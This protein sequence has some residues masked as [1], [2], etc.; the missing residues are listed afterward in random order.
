[1]SA[2][3]T[4]KRVALL[5][6]LA[7]G[8][9]RGAAAGLL[10]L[11]TLAGPRVAWGAPAA[12]TLS[13]HAGF[14][15]YYK[16]LRWLPVRITVAN[17]G[18]DTQ[19]T[20]RVTVPR[21]GGADV[22]VTRDVDLPTQS[23]REVF[24][25]I[26]TEG[27]ISNL[28]VSLSDGQKE[29]AT[30]VTRL[31]QAGTGDLIYG[32]LAG[33]P[34]AFNILSGVKPVSGSAYVAQLEAADL[35]PV[36]TAWHALD[37]LVISDVDTGVL[38]P[39]QRTALSEWVAS[40]GRLIVTGGPTWQKT[41]AGLGALLP[42]APAGTQTLPDASA[43]AAFASATTPPGS[44]VAATG[45]LGPDAVTLVS[46]GN[47]PIVVT[48]HSGFG[49]VLFLAIDPSFDPLKGWSGLEGLYRNLLS[50]T[51]QRPNWATGLRNWYAARDAVNALPGLQLPSALQVCGFLGVY[52]LAVGPINYLVLRRFKRRELAWLTVPL[53][54]VVFSGGAYLT[55]YQLRGG[56]ASL[57]RLAVVQVWPNADHAR[58]DGL[59]GLFSPRRTQY[60]LVFGQGFIARPMP[61]DTGS[62]GASGFTVQQSDGTVI[63]GVRLEVG[64]VEPFVVQG[65]VAAPAFDSTLT[66]DVSS[67]QVILQGQVTNRSDVALTDAVL[68]APGGVQRLG[69]LG[70]GGAANISL[71]LTSSHATLASPDDVLPAQ[72]SGTVAP[73]ATPSA[74][75]SYDSTIDDILGNTYHYNDREQFRRFS[76][77]SSIIDTYS[78]SVRG[79]GVYLVG[80]SN[81]SPVAVKL[82]NRSF[83]TVD[84]SLYF[85]SLQPKLNLGTGTLAIPPGLMT[86]LSLDPSPSISPTPYDLYLYQNTGVTLRFN[87]A[88]ALPHDKVQ[89]LTMH[90]LSYGQTGAASV[91]IDLWDFGAN[92]W[93]RQPQ[94]NWGDVAITNPDHF[95][96]SAGEIQVRA[97]NSTPNQVSLERLDFT[98]L[99]GQ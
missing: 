85:V 29:L 22:V 58:V 15:G 64:A 81:Q 75:S 86:W 13:I 92:N 45:S 99:V 28:H 72:A 9:L 34:S 33:S 35:P 18:A 78:G 68:L 5:K 90:L 42:M 67:S 41:A 48:R 38:S 39:E 83:Q 44:A 80:W 43:L 88:Q 60:D 93:V 63:A 94:R 49:Q 30:A 62:P 66:L 82:A 54:V 74:P 40:G 37:V 52:I 21:N 14:D 31:V 32:V 76:L 61:I 12:V 10:G 1:M 7:A 25:Y 89:G 97:F 71:P 77:L 84:S 95:V 26:P 16:D 79:N 73:A 3:N 11:A 20:L 59:V 2:I 23:R 47:L 46:A 96:G 19:G 4:I 6:R 70:P 36:S 98:L 69:N 27:F 56:Q 87:P 51:A 8:L 57:H 65:Q 55:G 50:G 17:D 53:L 91:N 24:L